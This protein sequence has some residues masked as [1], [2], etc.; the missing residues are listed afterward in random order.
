[1]NETIQTAKLPASERVEL[2]LDDLDAAVVA[3][4]ERAW[5]T[6]DVVELSRARAL[7]ST[8]TNLRASIFELIDQ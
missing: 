1:M 4:F 6:L 3:S 5:K 2:F 7:E 8:A